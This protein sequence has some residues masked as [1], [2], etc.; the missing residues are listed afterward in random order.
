MNLIIG[1]MLSS[2]LIYYIVIFAFSQEKRRNHK[3]RAENILREEA[4]ATLFAYSGI[5]PN[6][7][8]CC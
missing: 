1:F 3:N 4:I 8:T 2:L 6:I 5:A 7:F